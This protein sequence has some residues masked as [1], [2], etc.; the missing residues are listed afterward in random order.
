MSC[1][2]LYAQNNKDLAKFESLIRL[3]DG[4]YGFAYYRNAV[5]YYNRA[6][7]ISPNDAHANYY[8]AECYRNLFEYSDAVN[9]YKIASENDIE[10]FPLSGFYYA[11]MLK[12]Q[13]NYDNALVRFENFIAKTKNISPLNFK[14]KKAIF[15]RTLI[16]MEGCYWSLEQ[17]FEYKVTALPEP[18]NTKFNDFGAIIYKN[19]TNLLVISGREESK[20]DVKTD[21]G[22]SYTNTFAFAKIDSI[23]WDEIQPEGKFERINSKFNEGSG[24]FNSAQNQYFF[25]TCGRNDDGYCEIYFSEKNNSGNWSEP[26]PLNEN[27]N[28]PFSDNKQPAI[29]SNSDTL[30]FISNRVGG[31]GQNDLWFSVWNKELNNWGVAANMGEIINS[32][33]NEVSPFYYTDENALF[34]SSDGH[35]GFGGLDIFIAKNS[36]SDTYSVTNLGSPFNS[37][38]DD[39][40]FVLGNTKGYITSNREGSIGEFDIYFFNNM[41]AQTKYADYHQKLQELSDELSTLKYDVKIEQ[42]EIPEELMSLDIQNIYDRILSAKYAAL[43]YDVVLIFTESDYNDFNPLSIDDKSI[44]DMLYMSMEVNITQV[45]IDSIRKTDEVLYHNLSFGEKGF[46]DKISEAYFSTSGGSGFI[47]MSK[48]EQDFYKA[49]QLEEK[50]KIDRIINY[51]IRT[52][53]DKINAQKANVLIQDN[54]GIEE[55]LDSAV[56]QSSYTFEEY[57]SLISKNLAGVLYSNEWKYNNIENDIFNKMTFEDQ[58]LMEMDYKSRAFDLT[59]ENIE[60]L[61]TEDKE[62]YNQLDNQTKNTINQLAEKYLHSSENDVFINLNPNEINFYANLDLNGKRKYDR[63]L[64]YKVNQLIIDSIASMSKEI[65]E[66][67]PNIDT[68]IVNQAKQNEYLR[69]VSSKTAGYVYNLKFPYTEPDYLLSQTMNSEDL[70]FVDAIYIA[71]IQDINDNVLEAIQT[72]DI[73]N[74]EN[75]NETDKN[76]VNQIAE[77]YSKSDYN[78]EFV[79][80]NDAQKDFYNNLNLETKKKIDRLIAYKISLINKE[81]QEA[82]I[83]YV[84]ILTDDLGITNN[85]EVGKIF[86]DVELQTIE[87]LLSYKLAMYIYRLSMVYMSPDYA[88]KQKMSNENLSILDMLYSSKIFAYKEPELLEAIHKSDENQYSLLSK[89][90]REFIERQVEI[91]IFTEDYEPKISITPQDSLW[92]AN[93]S[94]EEKYKIDRLLMYKLNSRLNP[95]KTVLSTEDYLVSDLLYIDELS[96]TGKII[97]PEEYYNYERITSFMIANYIYSTELPF[98]ENDYFLNSNFTDDDLSII[99]MMYKSKLIALQDVNIIDSLQILDEKRYKSATYD[100]KAFINNLIKNYSQSD[101]NSLF[102]DLNSDDSTFY[103]IQSTKQKYQLDRLIIMKIKNIQEA[104]NISVQIVETLNNDELNIDELSE[105]TNI[106]TKTETN[107]YERILTFKLANYIYDVELP[108]N[109]ADYFLNE[110]LTF[111]E[112]SILEMMY[113]VKIYSLDQNLGVDSII[114]ADKTIFENLNSDNKNLVEEI[115]IDYS[116]INDIQSF[117]TLKPKT[118]SYYENISVEQKFLIDRLVASKLSEIIK[119]KEKVAEIEE[120]LTNDDF[121][122][123][124]MEISENTEIIEPDLYDSYEKILSFKI[125]NY[126]HDVELQFLEPDYSIY[127]NLTI[128]DKSIID[129]MFEMRTFA[130]EDTAVKSILQK[131]DEKEYLTLSIENK[132]LVDN[133][134]NA[135]VENSGISE[136]IK[137]SENDLNKYSN[138]EIKDKNQIDRIISSQIRQL[139]NQT[140]LSNQEYKNDQLSMNISEISNISNIITQE[141]ITKYEKIISFKIANYIYDLDL[142]FIESDKNILNNFTID[143]NS[144]LEMMYNAR[145]YMLHEDDIQTFKNGDKM[146]I[147]SLSQTDLNFIDNVTQAYNNQKNANKIVLSN[148]DAEYYKNLNIIQKNRIDRLIAFKLS[149]SD[150][151]NYQ[152]IENKDSVIIKTI[153]EKQIEYIHDTTYIFSTGIPEKQ[154]V[155]EYIHDTTYVY[156]GNA[157]VNPFE[158]IFFEYN[159]TALTSEAKSKLELIYNYC[160][161]KPNS[162]LIIN[163]YTDD[164]GSKDYNTQLS[165]DRATQVFKFFIDKGLEKE[166]LDVYSYGIENPLVPNSNEKQ[167]EL[168][169]RV[170]I[171]ILE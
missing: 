6:L 92:Y 56:N 77:S 105:E 136:F 151:T 84:D 103:G 113:A 31:Y 116:S 5:D 144:I 99:E 117:V 45:E 74:Y 157:N 60:N 22:E 135:F 64:A 145:T 88:L 23:K 9:Y 2:I 54:F 100:N 140:I 38:L 149:S 95:P 120:N 164:T 125:A 80:L 85:Q 131:N 133:I 10:N 62:I 52:E 128:D 76:V 139:M 50:Q 46:V 86:T 59:E 32:P 83:K 70:G 154:I 153:I 11:L 40:Y 44:I 36:N 66:I 1:N 168:N 118:K 63:I 69:L 124:V 97:T 119:E 127:K 26:K 72:S 79:R 98:V 159:S 146:L 123:S 166:K 158:I 156:T 101:E 161:S 37:N 28:S 73:S 129:M 115:I 114:E 75:L 61:K 35:K 137:L 81:K 57:E 82:A 163:G 134:V 142:P 25:S 51:K 58:S 55:L 141:D 160:K 21:L 150:F 34:F 8:T 171:L 15:Q 94:V 39:C 13:G 49:L 152:N 130:V 93:L 53:I 67:L 18:V 121:S 91:M 169:R 167:R 19:D 111:D 42:P 104:E 12:Y 155:K 106:I 102:I 108:F 7:E 109:D 71:Q 47:K 90:D 165:Y 138:F 43:V 148:Y 65:S 147:S 143:D 68:A 78:S 29:S 87:K 27:I 16:E 14:D 48:D 17:L 162:T 20:F 170:Q 126:I 122:L 30:F 96:K 112:Q 110:K 4:Q 132:T 24:V 107:A 41:F 3:A 33:F 89:N